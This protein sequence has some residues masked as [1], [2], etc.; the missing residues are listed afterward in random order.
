[1]PK[2]HFNWIAAIVLVIALVVLAVTAFGLRKWQRNRMAHAARE[3]GLKAY[4]NHNW[5]DAVTNLGRYVAVDKSDIGILLKYAEAQLNKRPLKRSNIQ[6][7]IATYRTILRVD[8]SNPIAAEKLIG[9]Y[10]KMNIAAEAE[11]IAERY[12]QTN[13]NPTIRTML[14]IS[15]AKQRKFRE[16]AAQLKAIIEEHP[17]QM[18]AYE[19]LGKLLEQ[20]PEDFAEQPQ[21]WFDKAVENN[22][23]SAQAYII[24]AAFH[25]RCKNTTQALEDLKCAEAKDLSD[26]LIR[27]HLAAEFINANALDKA[28]KHLIAARTA[29]PKNQMLWQIWA[30]L[31]LRSNSKKQMFKVAQEGLTELSSQPWD[32][33]PVAAELF[34]RSGQLDQASDCLAKLRKKDIAAAQTAFLEGLIAA[35]KGRDTQAI[36]CW[37]RAIQLGNKSAGIR[38]E[39]SAAL[40]RAGDKQSALLQARSVITDHPNLVE[41]HLNL[42]GLLAETGN[43]AEAAEQARIARQ[44]SP[45]NL[46]AIILYTESRLR[47]LVANRTHRQ[48]LAWQ[49][50]EEELASLD[51]I[52]GGALAVKLLQVQLAIE[53]SQFDK[54]ERLL[55]G[56][57]HNYPQQAEVTMVEVELLVAQNRIDVAILK[58]ENIVEA[59]PQSLEPA[60]RLAI[61]LAVTDKRQKCENI[62]KDTM[63]RFEQLAARRQLGLLLANLYELWGE[64]EKCYRLLSWLSRDLPGDIP[65]KRRLLRCEKVIHDGDFAQQLVDEIRAIEGQTGWQWRCEQ[66]NVWFEAQNFKSRY[67]QILALL[68]ENLAADPADQTSRMLLAA[69]YEKAGELQLAV[70]TYREALS[71]SPD[72]I[73]IIVPTV[74]ALYKTREYKQADEILERVERKKLTHP[75]ISKLKL[76]S[77]LRQG[78]LS[79]A[80]NILED[81]MAKDSDNQTIALSLALLKMRRNKYGRARELLSGLKAQ[82]PQSLPITA[83]LIELNIR[84][85]NS[86][87][88][89]ALCDEMV[90]R[91]GNASAYILR[92]KTYQI[93]GRN[94]FAEKD[95][96]RATS[97]EPGNVQ[98]WMLKSDFNR[99]IGRVQ[100]AVEDIRKA[101]LLA[102]GN[103]QIQKRAITLLLSCSEP[104]K[105]HQGL[106]LLDKALSSNPDDVELRLHKARSLLAKRPH[107]GVEQARHILQRITQEQ[108]EIAQAWALLTQVCLEQA[109]LT[110]AT[111]T[112]L[113]GLS[114]SPNDKNLLRLKARAEAARSPVLAIPTLKLLS[115]REPNDVDIALELANTYIAAGQC[116]EGLTVLKRLLT[117]CKENDRRK[118]NIALAVALYKNGDKAEAEQQFD[119]LYQSMPDD[120]KVFLAEAG[121]LKDDRR[122]AELMAKV[123]ARSKERPHDTATFITL[124]NKL[125][126]TKDKEAQKIAEDVFQ[127]VLK[128]SPDSTEAISA[129]AMLLQITGR[130][131]Q[132]AGLYKRLL[133]LEPDSVVAVNN[134][135]WIM[136]EQ[137]GRY[138]QALELA[139][140]GLR[141]A[142]EYVDLIDTRGVIYYRLGQFHKAARD[143]T[144]CVN[145]YSDETPSAAASYLHLARALARLGQKDRAI[146]SLNRALKLNAELDG[147]SPADITE[148]Q[149]LIEGLSREYNDAP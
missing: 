81:L 47:L 38:L 7:A 65:V 16:A 132:S 53:C 145:L 55:A 22:N 124:A 32:F 149:R 96:E 61:L 78:K 143:F 79:S 121:L 68:K 56:I 72:N 37:Q 52:T 1:M 84:Q 8:G 40:S 104:D 123:D 130:S 39:L 45:D 86:Q 17:E 77:C 63:G 59:L 36:K 73:N 109:Q 113:R 105:M 128:S 44:I 24:R 76:Q 27:L 69:T 30:K 115:E 120:P 35:Q 6:Q 14:A 100:E 103:I 19:A 46:S 110:K 31:A 15:L 25:S 42:A 141:K 12:L 116:D 75:E 34:I 13:K 43:W 137:Q 4:E 83:A 108:P 129:L 26:P 136:C 74:A 64:H 135:A 71:H 11:L 49:H 102:P 122:W 41:T 85:K 97:I 89:L 18:P 98:A 112:A 95:F 88:A 133:E 131:E 54:A 134:L 114:Y 101:M 146:E 94:D 58:L 50:I 107:P 118:I 87:E 93:L 57:S 147:L 127:M 33:L 60:K 125:A 80:E 10:L 91:L 140:L 28:E 48:D 126:A 5:Q 111:D 21:D 29:D 82:Q 138:T 2:R 9:L 117:R 92:A 142:P 51:K 119:L 20:R 66:A 139:Q 67:P 90:S 3:A 62:L 144:R 99:T 106:Q 23:S 148:A 70:I